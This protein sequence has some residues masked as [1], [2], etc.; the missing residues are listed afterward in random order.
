M[1]PIELGIHTQMEK[2][3]VLIITAILAIAIVSAGIIDFY[4]QIN[5]NVEVNGPE[6]YITTAQK[7]LINEI[8]STSG[9]NTINNEES[10]IWITDEELG[11]INS[12][13]TLSIDFYV[14]ANSDVV[15]EELILVFG[16][17]DTS[18]TQHEICSENII[19]DTLSPDYGT[20][21]PIN[22]ESSIAINDLDEFY[23]EIR[24]T[25]TDCQYKIRKIEGHNFHTKIKVSHST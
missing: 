5:Q 14:V 23:Y 17:G 16:Y 22:C 18:E 4:G 15:D 12:D 7:L 24:G 10:E 13:D 25:C 9:T 19:I 11:G 1:N 20:Y 21:G 8:G 6:F 2:K 3:T